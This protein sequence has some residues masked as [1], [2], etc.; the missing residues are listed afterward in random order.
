MISTI[1]KTAIISYPIAH[2][3][4]KEESSLR[5]KKSSAFASAT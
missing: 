2:V 1:I 5:D 4:I 3:R